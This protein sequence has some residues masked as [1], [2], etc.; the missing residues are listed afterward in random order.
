MNFV[1]IDFETANAKRSSITSVGVSVVRRWKIVKTESFLVKPIP[2]YYA[3]Y[4][5]LIHGLTE[6]DTRYAKTFKAQWKDLRKYI[7]KQVGVAH[8]ASFESSALRS[9]LDAY[10]LPYP[11]LEYHCTLRLT[12]ASLKLRRYSLDHVCRHL[13]IP[14]KH[15]QAESDAIACALVA[16]R[17]CKRYNAKSLKDLN[18]KLGLR[19]GRI[20]AAGR[21]HQK[22]RKT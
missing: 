22:V 3:A 4:N 6:K 5:S 7:D 2:N 18:R 19:P 11:D 13:K 9:V 15:H 16:I 10:S 8:N 21:L 12:K 1:A 17:L 20:S 14:L